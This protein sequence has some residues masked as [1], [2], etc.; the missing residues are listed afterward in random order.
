[1]WEGSKYASN[2]ADS[3]PTFFFYPRGA[4][5][6]RWSARV[7]PAQLQENGP[8]VDQ[9]W[10]GVVVSYTDMLGVVRTVGP[11][12]STANTTDSRLL[13]SDP[14]NPCNQVPGLK[15]W[16]TLQ[17][18][19]STWD[20]AIIIGQ[21]FLLQQKLLNT[22][23]QAALTGHVLDEQGVYWPAWR[24]RAGDYISFTDAHDTRYRRI[25][26]SEYSDS[27]YT[28]TISLDVPP[29]GLQEL[30]DRLGV[31]MQAVGFS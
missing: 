6:K 2:G 19:T 27:T 31:G 30:L 12:G 25:V 13:D 11:P 23:G 16:T 17:M 21:I 4:V 29:D 10:N 18:G 15:R 1:V 8:Q 22:S 7:G 26:R 3:V 5:G 24:V 14:A 20:V 9:L 28:N